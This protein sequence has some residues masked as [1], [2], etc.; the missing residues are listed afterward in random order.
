MDW[1]LVHDRKWIESGLELQC[2]TGLTSQVLLFF[3]AKGTTSLDKIS[4]LY[5]TVNISKLCVRYFVF[6]VGSRAA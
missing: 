3:S 2:K 5:S 1:N 6:F 4:G